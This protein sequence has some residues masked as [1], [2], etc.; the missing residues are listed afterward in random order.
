MKL[1]DS[2]GTAIAL[3][4]NAGSS[5]YSNLA[6]SNTNPSL[7]KVDDNVFTMA[8]NDYLETFSANDKDYE[9]VQSIIAY[10]T[11]AERT[12]DESGIRRKPNEG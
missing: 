2:S 12:F 10:C 6:F 5:V 8:L 1:T 11:I 4:Q 3:Y 7:Y 9:L